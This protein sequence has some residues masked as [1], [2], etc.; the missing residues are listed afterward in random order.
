MGARLGAACWL[1][2]DL[3]ASL[4]G[5]AVLSRRQNSPLTTTMMTCQDPQHPCSSRT[6]CCMLSIP[7]PPGSRPQSPPWAKPVASS[8]EPGHT[9]S[10][11][12]AG[13]HPPP[14]RLSHKTHLHL[15]LRHFLHP[16]PNRPR[17]LPSGHS[18]LPPPPYSSP[19]NYNPHFQM[20]LQ[21]P[22]T[23][24]S[25]QHFPTFLTVQAFGD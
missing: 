22:V 19:V 7:L 2:P 17:P 14:P 6:P 24:V 13:H 18:A 25:S 23:V 9:V 11:L 20:W 12:R 21:P 1:L 16:P 15:P 4:D 8:K 3:G 5:N 10:P